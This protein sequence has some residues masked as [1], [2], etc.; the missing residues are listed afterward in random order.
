MAELCLVLPWDPQWPRRRGLER[1]AIERNSASN[2]SVRTPSAVMRARTIGS[3]SISSIDG[4]GVFHLIPR[5][6]IALQDRVSLTSWRPG[7]TFLAG[8]RCSLLSSTRT[9]LPSDERHRRIEDHLIAR[10]DSGVHFHLRAHIARHSHLAD[11]RL[12]IF[13]DRD[14]QAVAVEDDGLGGHDEGSASC[15]G[16]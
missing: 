10:L 16:S 3:A 13:D 6:P 8:R 7:S 5:P 11:L 1:F 9:L 14:L 15:A 12:A 2:S 4:S